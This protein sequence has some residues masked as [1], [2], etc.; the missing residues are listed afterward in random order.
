MKR[1]R[2]ALYSAALAKLHIE[3]YWKVKGISLKM[4]VCKKD[5]IDDKI[6][7]LYNDGWSI[8][9]IVA[10]YRATAKR[11]RGVLQDKGME[12]SGYRSISDHLR[13]RILALVTT[14]IA[15]RELGERVDLSSHLVRQVL[16]DRNVTATEWR[17][18]NNVDFSVLLIPEKPWRDFVAQYVL[19]NQGFMLCADACGFSPRDCA[20]AVLRLSNEEVVLHRERLYKNVL[21]KRSTG[22]S[23]I[24]VGKQFGI[25]PALVKRIFAN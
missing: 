24:S 21:S 11:V 19:G 1:S 4:K 5:I 14:G 17:M 7:A 12:T 8:N 16:R 18:Q 13:E 6:V 3:S 25:S 15:V 9:D 20:E 22:L 23:A 2:A 10:H